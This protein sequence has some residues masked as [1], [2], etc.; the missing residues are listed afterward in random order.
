MVKAI[1]DVYIQQ[2]VHS[3]ASRII[4]LGRSGYPSISSNC[5]YYASRPINEA[6][7]MVSKV[8]DES[9]ATLIGSRLHPHYTQ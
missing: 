7:A 8:N 2:R 9:T 3:D 5:G 6:D 4:Q 1:H